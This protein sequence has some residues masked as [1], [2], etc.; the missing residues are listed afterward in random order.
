MCKRYH[1]NKYIVV[2]FLFAQNK[3]LVARENTSTSPMA[4]N[5]SAMPLVFYNTVV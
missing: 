5:T 1:G 3:V 4:Q 2:P